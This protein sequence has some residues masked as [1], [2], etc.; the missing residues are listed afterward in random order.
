MTPGG[1]RASAGRDV[2][3]P[4]CFLR[5]EVRA[6]GTGSWKAP[7]AGSLPGRAD[8]GLDRVRRTNS[9]TRMPVGLTHHVVRPAGRRPDRVSPDVAGWPPGCD[10]DDPGRGRG[11]RY[12]HDAR[13][14]R[15]D[16]WCHHDRRRTDPDWWGNHHHGSRR[17]R[18]KRRRHPAGHDRPGKRQTDRD[19]HAHACVGDRPGGGDQPESQESHERLRIHHERFDAGRRRIFDRERLIDTMLGGDGV[20]S[21]TARTGSNGGPEL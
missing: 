17:R 3:A 4:A 18:R 21:L 13:R 6:P 10:H 7:S 14:N 16:R 8:T 20:M 19:L 12:D 1:A 2:P 11:R 5:T 15:D 9:P